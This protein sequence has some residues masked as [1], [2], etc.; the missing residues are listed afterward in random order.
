LILPPQ[1]GGS[2]C[3]KGTSKKD[4]ILGAFRKT[5]GTAVKP[6]E[7]VRADSP[8]IQY[9]TKI[10]GPVVYEE[11]KQ[12][13]QDGKDPEL[14]ETVLLLKELDA[15]VV[16]PILLESRL[17]GFIVLGA[18]RSGRL[19]SESDLSVFAILA[20]QAALAIENLRSVE[21]MKRTQEKLF[22][23]EKLAYVGQLASAVVHEVRNPL[24]AIKTF[25]S[26]LP[27]RF[28]KKDL[29]FLDRFEMIIPKEIGRMERMVEQ[30]LDLAKPERMKKKEL[31]VSDVVKETLDLLKDNV[32][33][34][35]IKVES[36]CLTEDDWVMGDKDKIQQ[37]VLNLVLN[38]LDAMEQGGSLRV[39]VWR[40]NRGGS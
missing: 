22:H 30:L 19:F 36:A 32:S 12:S 7:A 33:L 38:A 5:G 29:E 34:R 18:K 37:V 35:G 13:T 25:V 14:V 24:T 10:Q 6:L 15:A 27:E 2:N 1:G 26:Y 31:R 28:R 20:N 23:A 8:L 17:L 9:L 39:K 16:V 21:E 4:F 3:F 40:E 11:L